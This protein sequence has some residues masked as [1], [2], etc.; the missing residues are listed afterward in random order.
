MGARETSS[1]SPTTS[2]NSI[3]SE[4]LSSETRRKCSP[5]SDTPRRWPTPTVAWLICSTHKKV[6]G[7]NVVLTLKTNTQNST[8]NSRRRAEE[9]EKN[10]SSNKKTTSQIYQ[11][12]HGRKKS[13]S[14]KKP[15]KTKEQH[16]QQIDQTHNRAGCVIFYTLVPFLKFH[17]KTTSTNRDLESILSQLFSIFP[18]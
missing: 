5:P 14:Q 10:I 11:H 2:P 16:Q 7:I 1:P 4:P 3:N 17:S 15:S 13:T 12:S 9:K 8:K 18:H 6:G